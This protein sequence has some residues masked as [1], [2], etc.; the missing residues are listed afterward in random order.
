VG[1]G[2]CRSLVGKPGGRRPLGR[3]GHRWVANITMDLV[4]TG[5]VGVVMIR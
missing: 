1:G 5:W 2:M 4:D 3:P